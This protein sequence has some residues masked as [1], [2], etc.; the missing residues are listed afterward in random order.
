MTTAA[1]SEWLGVSTKT[2]CLWAECKEI[3][4]MKIGRS[5]LTN[6]Q[7]AAAASAITAITAAGGATPIGQLVR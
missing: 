3:P 7:V 2:L 4:A 1:V 5:A 6:Y